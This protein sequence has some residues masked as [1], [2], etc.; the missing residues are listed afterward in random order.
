MESGE[1]KER[2][3]SST[4]QSPSSERKVTLQGALLAFTRLF[5]DQCCSNRRVVLTLWLSLLQRISSL[6][7]LSAVLSHCFP[8]DEPGTPEFKTEP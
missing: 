2:R 6:R 7:K 8:A 5:A 3:S 1:K 4:L